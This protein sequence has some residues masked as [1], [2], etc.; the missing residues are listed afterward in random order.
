MQFLY[1]REAIGKYHYIA[2]I[3]YLYYFVIIIMDT[4]LPMLNIS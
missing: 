4:S 3:P 2:K 1:C